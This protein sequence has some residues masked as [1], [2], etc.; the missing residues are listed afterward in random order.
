MSTPTYVNSTA[1]SSTY[2]GTD[3]STY[4]ATLSG[5]I[6]A[7][8]LIL[9]LVGSVNVARWDHLKLIVFPIIIATHIPS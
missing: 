7:G 5:T 6:Q 8:D 9:V 2:T 4:T 1:V 3:P